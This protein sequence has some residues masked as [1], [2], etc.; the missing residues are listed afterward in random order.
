MRRV[1]DD[2]DAADEPVSASIRRVLAQSPWWYRSPL[3]PSIASG[4]FAYYL[5]ARSPAI[6]DWRIPLA[7][8]AGVVV[9]SWIGV[10]GLMN[11]SPG[12]LRRHAGHYIGVTMLGI[13][14]CATLGG[15]A[16]IVV[17]TFR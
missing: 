13:A 7:I 10:L 3:M 5:I 14:I 6:P 2:E 16:G 15:V 1:N 17:R 9:A 4:W 8:L 12:R 11:R